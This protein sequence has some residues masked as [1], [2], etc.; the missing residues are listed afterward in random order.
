MLR[1]IW[2]SAAVYFLIASQWSFATERKQSDPDYQALTILTR[3]CASCH[4]QADHPG[5]LFLNQ[6]RLN[7]PETIE[8]ITQLVEKNEM[9]PA[10]ASFKKTADGKTLLKWLKNKP[11]GVK[12]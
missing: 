4:N 12:K 6:A 10:H 5:A 3:H 11:N 1:L 2:I 8:L 9:P 7:E